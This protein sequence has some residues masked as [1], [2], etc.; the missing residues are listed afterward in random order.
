MSVVV[1]ISIVAYLALRRPSPSPYPPPPPAV[2][3]SECRAV[4][5]GVD[6]LDPG[7]LYIRFD[8]PEATFAVS[9][10]LPDMFPLT[11][12]Y[13]VTPKK[14]GA[15]TMQIA[16]GSTDFGE[17]LRRAWPFLTAHFYRALPAGPL[18]SLNG[19]GERYVRD[20]HG[21][22]V[23]KDRWGY[24][25][26][27]NRWRLVKSFYGEEAGYFPTPLREAQLFDQIISSACVLAAPRP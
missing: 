2:V 6:R 11:P 3:V 12:V 15:H 27:G 5:P 21:D 14:A 16:N 9:S 24:V 8:I 20:V 1:I 26:N 18:D 7:T 10:E 17:A 13:C 4:P 22:V 23:G 19:Y 25:K